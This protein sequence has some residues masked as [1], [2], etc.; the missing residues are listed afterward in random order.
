MIFWIIRTGKLW[1]FLRGIDLE[2]MKIGERDALQLFRFLC[3]VCMHNF[4]F[5]LWSILSLVETSLFFY[6]IC[7]QMGM[8]EDND[9]VTTKTRILS[10]ELLQ[11]N[12][13]VFC[14]FLFFL[15]YWITSM[16]WW[17][18]VYSRWLWRTSHC[19]HKNGG[20]KTK[21]LRVELVTQGYNWITTWLSLFN[22]T[23]CLWI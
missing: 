19:W 9:E 7:L 21:L 1:L 2:S 14:L 13:R 4:L 6:T 22:M 12:L 16:F 3:K 18:D 11:V 23:F 15:L 5:L 10:L 20:T 17:L 8:K